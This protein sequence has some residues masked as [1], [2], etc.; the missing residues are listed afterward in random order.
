MGMRH[1]GLTAVAYLGTILKSSQG[2]LEAGIVKPIGESSRAKEAARSLPQPP[3]I[4]IR[5]TWEE[6]NVY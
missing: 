1:A 3:I 2:L 6:R 4:D 5:S